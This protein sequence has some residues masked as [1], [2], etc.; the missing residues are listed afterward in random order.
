MGAPGANIGERAQAVLVDSMVQ[1]LLDM[2][3]RAWQYQVQ[4]A[5]SLVA[6]LSQ[7]ITALQ[8]HISL[9]EIPVSLRDPQVIAMVNISVWHLSALRGPSD[10]KSTMHSTGAASLSQPIIESPAEVTIKQSLSE[11]SVE[12]SS[13]K[14]PRE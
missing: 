7:T 9:H 10:G 3:P 4:H 6:Q 12:Q 14:P 13:V 1:D 11:G 5:R 2:D 8:A